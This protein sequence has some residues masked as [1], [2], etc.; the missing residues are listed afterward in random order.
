MTNPHEWLQQFFQSNCDGEWEHYHG[1]RIQSMSDPGWLLRFDL[2]GTEHENKRLDE[3]ADP[4]APIDWLK[5]KPVD[6]V[7]EAQCSPRRLAE[8][9]EILRDVVEGRRGVAPPKEDCCN[10]DP[11]V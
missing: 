4:R 10:D 7:F 5:C 1:C 2:T 8:C 11:D 6:G 9:I 3:L